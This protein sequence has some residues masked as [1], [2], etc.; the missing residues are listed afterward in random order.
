MNLPCRY[1]QLDVTDFKRYDE[2]VAE[3]K[4]D[5][6]VHLAAILSALGE[7]FPDRATNVN[8]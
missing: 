1:E 5:Y 8:V 7:R 6:I 4:V 2:I 3:H